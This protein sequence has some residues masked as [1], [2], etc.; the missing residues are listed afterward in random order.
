MAAQ[1]LRAM[2]ATPPSG[3]NMAGGGLPASS[4]M[5]STPGTFRAAVLST[6]FNLPPKTGGRAMTAY[7]MPS[8]RVSMPKWVLPVTMSRRSM[9]RVLVWPM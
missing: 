6:L 4:T 3:L 9:P 7:A 5:R 8:R 2:T 1:V